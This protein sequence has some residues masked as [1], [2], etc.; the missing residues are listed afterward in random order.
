[1][2]QEN[3][4]K[5]TNIGKAR[6]LRRNQTD[7]EKKLWAML[8][9]RSFANVKFRRQLPIENYIL[10]FYSPDLKLCVEA[11]GGQHYTEEGRQHDEERSRVLAEFGIQI[12]RFSDRDILTNIEGVCEVIFREI[13][14][15]N[16]P[17][18]S[19]LPHG[20]RM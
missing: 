14:K 8:R 15:S 20:E 5:R 7:V 12:L 1:M 9:D 3:I 6:N 10:D 13:G 19:P 11:D 4:V 18:L 2:F 17:H 16:P